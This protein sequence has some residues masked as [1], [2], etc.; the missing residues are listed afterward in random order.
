[1][2]ARRFRVLTNDID[3]VPG[4]PRRVGNRNAAGQRQKKP[5]GDTWFSHLGTQCKVLVMQGGPELP[6]PDE[7][8]S[9]RFFTRAEPP[10]PPDVTFTVSELFILR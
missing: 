9:E 1:M 5:N 3:V 2:R 8:G 6:E 7:F 4:G 10:G